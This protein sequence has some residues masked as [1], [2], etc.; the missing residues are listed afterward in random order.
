MTTMHQSHNRDIQLP[1]YRGA[2]QSL[3]STVACPYDV[4]VLK[5]QQL[6]PHCHKIPEGGFMLRGSLVLDCRV[7][8]VRLYA[9][10]NRPHL[11]F[12]IKFR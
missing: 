9:D 1:F 10:F 5:L 12:H 4:S 8:T 6:I 7:F 3:L 2:S 11:T